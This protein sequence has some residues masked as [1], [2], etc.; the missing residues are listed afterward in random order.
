MD[1]KNLLSA[2]KNVKSS[3]TKVEDLFEV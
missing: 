1:I 3:P 2:K